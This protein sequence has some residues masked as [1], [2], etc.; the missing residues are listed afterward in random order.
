MDSKLD[1]VILHVLER[2][3]PNTYEREKLEKVTL[4]VKKRV[5]SEVQQ[6]DSKA[7]VEVG[8]SVAKDTWLS[9][10]ADIDVFIRFPGSISRKML[11]EVGL[12]IAKEA[13]KEFPWRERF[14]EHP[15]LEAY[16][17]GI[18]INIVPCY[19]VEKG[20]WKSAADRSPFHTE[21]VRMKLSHKDLRDEIRLLKR[22]TKGVGVYGAEIKV[23]GFSG[24]L[25]ELLIL[26]YQSFIHTLKDIAK[27]KMKQLVDIENLYEGKHLEAL[28]YFDAAL[29][30]I[31][32]IDVNRNVAAAVSQ[33]KFGELITAS[34]CF[35]EKPD[36]SFFYPKEII[37]QSVNV[38]TEKL[39]E[40][41]SDFVFV[42]FRC[43]P[44]VP[45]ILWGQLY[46]TT[47]ALKKLLKHYEF[48]VLRSSVWSDEKGVNVLLFELE[49]K[50]IPRPKRHIGPR[51]DSQEA[52]NFLNKH[53]GVKNTISRPWIEGNRWMVGISRSYVNAI[54][55]LREKIRDE[56]RSIGVAKKF[57]G[58]MKNSEIYINEEILKF[59][60]SNK[61]FA[62]FLSEFLNSKPNW[63]E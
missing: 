40:G 9:G 55:L 46:K 57:V 32:P 37:L 38:L 1:K 36:S 12:Q 16:I 11:G 4:L 15:Y 62:K 25:C 34:R 49:S 59:Y 29:I 7:I 17:D 48:S 45:D 21:Y 41:Q 14:A 53:L 30:V 54:S 35:L 8:G 51:F 56:G 33:E 20:K 61:E 27:W 23:G 5:I 42:I 13:L 24:Y 26:G 58:N 28:R 63:I 43:E 19:K 47:N 39:R 3:K 22:F 31:D 60:R 18:C 2:I 50:D 52:G 6:G 44:E 10:E